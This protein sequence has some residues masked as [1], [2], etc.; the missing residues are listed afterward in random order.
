[1]L[2]DTLGDLPVHWQCHIMTLNTIA[3]QLSGAIA[4]TSMPQ[5][6]AHFMIPL[7]YVHFV[8]D[9]ATH[10]LA[11]TAAAKLAFNDEEEDVVIRNVVIH[12][13]IKSVFVSSSRSIITT[14]LLNGS[15]T[16]ILHYFQW[17]LFFV[18]KTLCRLKRC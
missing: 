1:M 9:N 4:Y 16:F 12:H 5:P 14:L 2:H 10:S 3:L 18:T 17:C 8:A 7:T 13:S 6:A 15:L 11:S